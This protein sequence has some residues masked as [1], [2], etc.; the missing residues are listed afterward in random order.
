[1]HHDQCNHTGAFSRMLLPQ[2]CGVNSRSRCCIPPMTA[3]GMSAATTDGSPAADTTAVGNINDDVMGS[4]AGNGLGLDS[5]Q[6]RQLP[7]NA[8]TSGTT[9]AAG[10]ACD[11]DDDD[12]D[13]AAEKD[14]SI[15]H[16]GGQQVWA[17]RMTA[18]RASTWSSRVRFCAV[19]TS[20]SLRQWC[21]DWWQPIF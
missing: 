11:H 12:D 18:Y 17:A 2:A 9:A 3:G 19:H 4:A 10:G 5:C 1:M 16:E 7:L 6:H 15:S 8:H 14:D 20:I 21:A 13:D